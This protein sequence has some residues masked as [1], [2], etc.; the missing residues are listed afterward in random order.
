MG[1]LKLLKKK[2]L[3]TGS[4]GLL[5][6]KLVKQFLDGFEVYGIGRQESAA[7]TNGHYNYHQCDIT[8]RKSMTSLI[9][10]I[11]P[12]Y[13]VNSAAYT[14]VDGSEDDK[15]TCWK[16]NVTAVESLAVIAK[17]LN[18]YFMHISTDYVFDGSADIYD[19][20]ARP[21]PLGYYGKAKLAGENAVIGSGVESAIARTMVLFGAGIGLRL[22]FATW[23]VDK[24]QNGQPVN[25]VDDQFGHPTLVDELAFAV[26]QLTEVRKTGIFNVA[27]NEYDSRYA[28]ALKLAEVFGFDKNLVNQI[29]TSELNQNA[30]R[31]LRSRFDMSK[32]QNEIGCQ[33]SDINEALLKFK[34]QLAS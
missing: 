7:V 22:N 14:N 29:S 4:N 3:I 12:Q 28:F 10:S 21:N 30:P 11:E 33:L 18:A 25:I 16:V 13:I 17:S 31:P 24:L 19:E 5:G 26:R 23:L 27:G 6:Q 1:N 20:E 2:V 34:A 8:D 32:L 15:E 9:K